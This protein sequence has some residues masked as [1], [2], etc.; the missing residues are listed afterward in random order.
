MKNMLIYYLVF[1]KIF[2]NSDQW[3]VILAPHCAKFYLLYVYLACS[4]N[5][6]TALYVLPSVVS[7]ISFEESY[8][9]IYWTDFHDFF[10]KWKALV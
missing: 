1:G 5:L 8:L 10:T 2:V 6:P 3:S 4:A 9:R 7:F